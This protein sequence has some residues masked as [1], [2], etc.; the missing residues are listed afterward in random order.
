MSVPKSPKSKETT[1]TGR[2]GAGVLAAILKSL[3][4]V[5]VITLL[6]L[7]VVELG[8][9]LEKVSVLGQLPTQEKAPSLPAPTPTPTPLTGWKSEPAGLEVELLDV[10]ADDDGLTLT[11]EVRQSGPSALFF[12][13]PVLRGEKTYELDPD[14]L[15]KARY[16]LLDVVARGQAEIELRF[17]PAPEE[18]EELTLV[19]NPN[20]TGDNPVA[21]RIEVPVEH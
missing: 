17:T 3:V 15:E 10:K 20:H 16:D 6:A 12:E 9:I 2:R 21:P 7:Q 13:Q 19:F 18:G 11:L 14:S 8:L 1:A 4:T 5:L